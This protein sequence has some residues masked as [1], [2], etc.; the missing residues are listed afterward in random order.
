M[1]SFFAML[2]TGAD[3]DAGNEAQLLKRRIQEQLRPGPPVFERPG[4]FVADLTPDAGAGGYFVPA[5]RGGVLMGTVFARGGTGQALSLLPN[6]GTEP[7][8]SEVTSSLLTDV[9]GSYVAFSAS[10]EGLTVQTDPVASLP[11]YY[12][13]RG[14]LLLAFSHLEACPFPDEVQFRPEPDF[15]RAVLAYDRVQNGETG[16]RGVRELLA[17]QKL[18]LSR[19]GQTVTQVWDPRAFAARPLR[20]TEAEAAAALREAATEVIRA[21]TG[22]F[23]DI[24]ID[25]SGGF[26]SSAVAGLC[27]QVS[28]GDVRLLHHTLASGDPSEAGYARAVANHTGLPYTEILL[29]PETSLPPPEAHPRSARPQRQFLGRDLTEPLARA[30]L[31]PVEATFSGQGGDHL[32]LATRSARGAAD[33]LLTRGIGPSAVGELFNSA[34]LSGEAP[35]PVLRQTMAVLRSAEAAAEYEMTGPFRERGLDP[36]RFLPEWVREP[37]GLPPMKA[38]QVASLAHMV[39]VR[40]QFS[41]PWTRHMVHPL[42]SQPLIELCLRLPAWQLTAGGQER[43]LARQ[44]LAGAIPPEIRTRATKGTSSQFFMAHLFANRPQ[45]L[46]A[47]R[48]G[49]LVASGYL[50]PAE[51]EGFASGAPYLAR[52]ASR[53]MMTAYMVEAW[54]RA[55]QG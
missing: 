39:Q 28:E 54:L 2:W 53:R 24:R 4:L 51:L 48:D 5:G 50:D 42:I 49:H 52:R 25:L 6:Q 9:W 36:E 32:F 55:W 19:Q 27:A 30:G 26:D 34:R 11:C 15:I 33:Y 40:E 1:R 44:A 13:Q 29:H 8:G 41:R 20:C 47:L 17:G 43:G 18:T 35:W 7:S 37:A 23:R 3:P 21:W 22:H 38:A 12:L 14:K 10:P 16:I 45:I 31:G 46:A